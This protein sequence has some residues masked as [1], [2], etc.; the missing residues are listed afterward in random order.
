LLQQEPELMQNC[1]THVTP[2]LL[3]SSAFLSV[4]IVLT[5]S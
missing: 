3:F 1:R 2:P 4:L 5:C